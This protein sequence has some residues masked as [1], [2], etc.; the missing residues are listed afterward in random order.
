MTQSED[1]GDGYPDQPLALKRMYQEHPEGIPYKQ[2]ER[3][4]SGANSLVTQGT[5]VMDETERT[6][7]TGETG[8]AQKFKIKRKIAKFRGLNQLKLSSN[9]TFWAKPVRQDAPRTCG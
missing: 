2:H 5:F 8:F 1:K 9:P 6:I 7:R 3:R 4:R